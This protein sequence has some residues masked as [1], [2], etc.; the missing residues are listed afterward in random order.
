MKIPKD[1]R[2]TGRKRGRA[3]LFRSNSAYTCKVCSQSPKV[4]PP[5]APRNF[6]NFIPGDLDYSL[7][8]NHINKNILDNDRV[9]VQ[10]LCAPCHKNA[11][12]VTLKGVSTI[13]DEFGY[14]DY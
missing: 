3:V 9:N 6:E 8:C 2:S 5:D 13:S 12:K 7:Q 1:P 11:D 4:L 10:W 14:G